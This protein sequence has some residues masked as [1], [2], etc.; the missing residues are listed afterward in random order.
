MEQ[1]NVT[2]YT[3]LIKIFMRLKPD[4]D[5]LELT[6]DLPGGKD[7]ADERADR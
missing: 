5:Q 2:E 6:A 3:E 1:K 4:G 7:R